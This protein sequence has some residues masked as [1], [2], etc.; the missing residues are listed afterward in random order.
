MKY[1]KTIW[2]I[3]LIL[4][5]FLFRFIIEG[6]TEAKNYYTIIS[7]TSNGHGYLYLVSIATFN[8]FIFLMFA[9]TFVKHFS[10]Q[11]LIRL[12]RTVLFLKNEGIMFLCA[13]IFN[14]C[15]LLPHLLFYIIYYGIDSMK[16]I[17]F[18]AILICQF[19]VLI[20]YY[21]M[22]GNIYMLVY[23]KTFK[24]YIGFLIAFSIS[25]AL[26][27]VN[28]IFNIYTPIECISVFSSYYE[29]NNPLIL[30]FK[31]A[32]WVFVPIIIIIS[33]FNLFQIKNKDVISHE[34]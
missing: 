11:L 24:P 4:F 30:I 2:S 10:V 18:F 5:Y 6:K 8:C 28:M 31:N 32:F 15:F 23:I 26:T 9:N 1:R 17:H 12:K 33:I 16:E 21:F 25:V 13:L 29:S 22:I 7:Y 20:L 3:A 34:H 19:V 27:F 14:V